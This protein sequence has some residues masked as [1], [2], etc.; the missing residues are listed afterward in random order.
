M[1]ELLMLRSI[2]TLLLLAFPVLGA[3]P[4]YANEISDDPAP[5]AEIRE[6]FCIDP[7]ANSSG[8]I[9]QATK[10]AQCE[11]LPVALDLRFLDDDYS[12]LAYELPVA[13]D[14]DWESGEP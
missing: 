11:P 2:L 4:A 12:S 7:I 1:P 5:A 3:I 14:L 13:L 8:N 10:S 6:V 9:G